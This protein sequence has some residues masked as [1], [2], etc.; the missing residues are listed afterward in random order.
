MYGF[1]NKKKEISI[2]E[3]NNM[4]WELVNEKNLN[5]NDI[6][7]VIAEQISIAKNSDNNE[8]STTAKRLERRF[9]SKYQQSNI[10]V[11]Y[12]EKADNFGGYFM[13]L[14]MQVSS[15]NGEKGIASCLEALEY[16]FDL[17]H[18]QEKKN[19]SIE[20]DVIHT[21]TL[22]K[23]ELN[24]IRSLMATQ[25]STLLSMVTWYKAEILE[26][27]QQEIIEEIIN[28]CNE[29]IN[30][31][32]WNNDFLENQK[33]VNINLTARQIYV[34]YSIYLMNDNIKKLVGLPSVYS[35]YVE[36]FKKIIVN[37]ENNKENGLNMSEKEFVDNIK[38]L[39]CIYDEDNINI[40]LKI[41]KEH[42]ISFQQFLDFMKDE[43]RKGGKLLT[44]VKG[45]NHKDS[46]NLMFFI[47]IEEVQDLILKIS[48]LSVLNIILAQTEIIDII[49]KEVVSNASPMFINVIDSVVADLYRISIAIS[50][51]KNYSKVH[52]M[53]YKFVIGEELE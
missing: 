7:D 26:N 36:K 15:S 41:L 45:N 9:G 49:K 28:L 51:E 33:T 42:S 13:S 31:D 25:N 39:Y 37:L 4:V 53:N 16:A 32:S 20:N 29:I 1:N 2:E 10:T 11:N 5:S 14:L 21:V 50:I 24:D 30:N 48:E 44:I 43:I 23:H 19:N 12:N 3:I 27:R 35:N 34:I 17:K 40:A 6:A 47:R 46:R 52:G 22:T 18:K 38:N 8:V